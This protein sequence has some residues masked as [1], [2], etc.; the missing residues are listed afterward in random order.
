MVTERS[1][2]QARRVAEDG[3]VVSYLR[4][5]TLTTEQAAAAM[6]TVEELANLHG[7]TCLF[8]LTTL[9]AVTL[10]VNESPWEKGRLSE[11]VREACLQG[12]AR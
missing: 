4:G 3:W 2:H 6:R 5:R 9:E 7:L 8:G 11:P 12:A 10:A 1:R